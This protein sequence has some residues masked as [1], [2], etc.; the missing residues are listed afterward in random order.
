M[1][2]SWSADIATVQHWP[3]R[4]SSQLICWRS[5]NSSSRSSRGCPLKSDGANRRL[6]KN[7]GDM[8]IQPTA[9]GFPHPHSSGGGCCDSHF[10][11][12]G[13]LP[14]VSRLLGDCAEEYLLPML[15]P[16]CFETGRFTLTQSSW[17]AIRLCSRKWM[18]GQ[19]AALA[20]RT[21]R[22]QFTTLTAL[23]RLP[24]AGG[25]PSPLDFYLS[26]M[27]DIDFVPAL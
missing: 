15:P 9:T 24:S 20:V 18:S 26:W 7:C 17:T 5:T 27:S 21:D 16:V 25:P 23:R 19:A 3:L 22:R 12:A 2:A 1:P 10:E 11:L 6:E 14:A 8:E 13:D 4:G